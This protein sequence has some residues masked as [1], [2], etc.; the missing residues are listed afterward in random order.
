RYTLDGTEPTAASKALD[1]PLKVS[2]SEVFKAAT[3]PAEGKQSLTWTHIDESQKFAHLG[4]EI[5]Q[6]KPGKIGNGKPEEVTF[7]A[8]GII[9]S[10]GTYLITFQYTGGTQRQD[11]DG[12]KVF[13][14]E[15]DLVGEDVHHGF[16]GSSAKDNTYEIDV[17]AYQ[18]G[19]SFQVKAMIYG[20]T[21]D[22]SNGVVLIRKK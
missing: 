19:A 5:G 10:N 6:W 16:T 1:G 3:F 18:T 7:D 12:V 13:R 9:D 17:K 2:K 22:D 14:N 20:D 11:I 4:R 8:T 15:T 21:G